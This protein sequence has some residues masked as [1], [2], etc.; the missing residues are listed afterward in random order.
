MN[1][2]N[3]EDNQSEE[4]I[5]AIVGKEEPRRFIV[6]HTRFTAVF[7]LN[8]AKVEQLKQEYQD[9]VQ[10]QSIEGETQL[11]IEV[12]TLRLNPL[13]IP[14]RKQWLAWPQGGF[15]YEQ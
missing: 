2:T 8:R 6:N 11:V 10:V 4:Q 7:G 13:R 9:G 14:K 5:R 15:F 3:G 1:Q 12:M